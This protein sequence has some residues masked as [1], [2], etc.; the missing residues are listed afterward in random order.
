MLIFVLIFVELISGLRSKLLFFE[1]IVKFDHADF[2][3]LSCAINVG[4]NDL[5]GWN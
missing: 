5:I 2:T 4:L 3:S 1:K